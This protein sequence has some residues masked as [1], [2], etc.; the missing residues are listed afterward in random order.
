L[1]CHIVGDDSNEFVHY[2]AAM[3]NGK[4]SVKDIVR[5]VMAGVTYNQVYRAAAIDAVTQVH[6]YMEATRGAGKR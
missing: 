3:V 5:Q 6:D 1:G 2:G 4:H